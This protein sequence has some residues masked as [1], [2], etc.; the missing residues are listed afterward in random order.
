MHTSIQCCDHLG[1]MYNNLYSAKEDNN[2]KIHRT[3]CTQIIV[4]VLH[5]LSVLHISLF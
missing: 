1:E 2:L 4:N 3:K 5:I